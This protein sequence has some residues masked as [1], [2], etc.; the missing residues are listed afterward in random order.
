MPLVK[1]LW[2]R[3]KKPCFSRNVQ[4]LMTHVQLLIIII[5]LKFYSTIWSLFFNEFI[6]IYFFFYIP[7]QSNFLSTLHDRI[8]I[9]CFLRHTAWGFGCSYQYKCCCCCRSWRSDNSDICW[10]LYP[11]NL[12][13]STF[14]D[15]LVHLSL[16][17]I[18][19]FRLVMCF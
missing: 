12:H 6:W 13:Q 11:S 2:F 1:A 19:E 14:G 17:W 18:E 16:Q 8:Y 9:V 4:F 7:H 10:L 3:H 5:K 15:K